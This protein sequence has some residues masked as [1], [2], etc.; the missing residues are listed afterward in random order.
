MKKAFLS[1]TVLSALLISIIATA[2][3]TDATMVVDV[4]PR[5]ATIYP[6]Q[7]VN[8]TAQVSYVQS[9]TVPPFN[10]QWYCNEF[11]VK[12]EYHNHECNYF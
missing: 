6:N 11:P 10:F 2:Q 12:F 3:T 1:A 7:S 8:F 5:E 9:Y 4:F